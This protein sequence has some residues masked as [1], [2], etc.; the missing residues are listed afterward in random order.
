M[1]ES[2]RRYLWDP[3]ARKLSADDSWVVFPIQKGQTTA[4]A[5]SVIGDWVVFQLNGAGSK[6]VASSITA[7]HRDDAKRSK[8]IFPFGPLKPGGFSF[9]PPKAG[10]DPENGMVYSADMGMG[11]V[12]GIKLDQASGEMKVAFVVDDV[13]STFQ[14]VIGPKDKRV[15]LFTNAKSNVGRSR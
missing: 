13:T 3:A 6:T 4:T 7:I 11:K 10:A 9:A 5:P 8:V 12:A 15:L 2:V 1:A 14:P